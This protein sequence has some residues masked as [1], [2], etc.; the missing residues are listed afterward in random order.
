M[1][2]LPLSLLLIAFFIAGCGIKPPAQGNLNEIIV[3]ADPKVYS[4]CEPALS[5]ALEQ[6]VR[7][8]Q[9]ET[10]FELLYVSFDKFT[11]SSSVPNILFL[12][13]LDS[14]GRVSEYVKGMLDA[15]TRKGVE[16]SQYWIFVKKDP[17]RSKQLAVILCANNI[18]E[19]DARIKLGEEDIFRQFNEAVLQQLHNTLYSSYTQEK[20]AE[21]LKAEYGFSL[22]IQ[23]D[24]V[25]VR[26]EPQ[27]RFL[28]LRRANPD[29]LFTISWTEANTLT[30]SLIIAERIRLGKLFSDKVYIY[31][32]YNQVYPDDSIYPG[33]SMLRGLWGTENNIGGGPFFTY[34]LH[35]Q[36][37]GMVYFLD[38]AVFNPG[39]EKFPFLQ[40]LE[41]MARTFRPPSK[42]VD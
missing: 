9:P 30:D 36:E 19:L 25:L 39:E 12:G 28:R 32:E 37:D 29:R 15:E 5:S 42:S 34:A 40:Q 22:K 14:G 26:D 24:Y 7:T 33:G 18:E 41:V 23:H 27:E 11:D 38:G 4:F 3:F 10:I 13:A 17:W 20:L 2:K 8:P 16:A 35:S 6:V 31:P 1:N 21:E